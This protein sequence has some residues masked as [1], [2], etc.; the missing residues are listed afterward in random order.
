MIVVVPATGAV[1]LT[2]P[3]VLTAFSCTTSTDVDLDARLRDSHAGHVL[4]DHEGEVG[5]RIDWLLA[6]AGTLGEDATW[7]SGFDKMLDYAESKGWRQGDLIV[8]H[9]VVSDGSTQ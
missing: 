5:I 4:E 3:S 8:S 7:R 9:V 2:E 1:E 6:Q